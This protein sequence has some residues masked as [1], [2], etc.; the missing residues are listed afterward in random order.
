MGRNS[1]KTA[2]LS[3]PQIRREY[4]LGLTTVRREAAR[5]SFPVYQA[6]TP[7]RPRV[8]RD[9]FESWLAS[10]LIDPFPPGCNRT[11]PEELRDGT[12]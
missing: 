2:L 10:T 5:G 12:A 6:G 3:F 11:A 7:H 8:R 9:E 1:G 4:G